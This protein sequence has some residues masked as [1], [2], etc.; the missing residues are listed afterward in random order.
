M[1]SWISV[2]NSHL[3]VKLNFITDSLLAKCTIHYDYLLLF[4]C[5]YVKLINRL[6]ES[7]YKVGTNLFGNLEIG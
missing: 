7:S 1:E 5:Y 2:T 4:M 6:S 3:N